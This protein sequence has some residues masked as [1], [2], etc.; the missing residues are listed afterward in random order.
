MR[1]VLLGR[2]WESVVYEREKLYQTWADGR[3]QRV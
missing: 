3:K 1:S 2:G